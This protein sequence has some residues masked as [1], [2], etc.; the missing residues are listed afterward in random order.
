MQFYSQDEDYKIKRAQRLGLMWTGENVIL[1]VT[2][3]DSW[4]LRWRKYYS[5]LAYGRPQTTQPTSY[6]VR[7]T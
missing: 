2:A 3:N 4:R 7:T 6:D 1:I 5:L